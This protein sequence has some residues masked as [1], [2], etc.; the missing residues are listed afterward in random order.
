MSQAL[1]KYLTIT[2]V[3]ASFFQRD[4]EVSDHSFAG[5]IA[6]FAP[7]QVFDMAKYVEA[8]LTRLHVKVDKYSPGMQPVKD[9]NDGVSWARREAI[10]PNHPFPTPQHQLP[11]PPIIMGTYG[12]D[13]KKKTL[14]VYGHYDVQP[15]AKSDGWDTEP[16]VLTER[17]GA[18]YGRG[19]SDDKGAVVVVGGGWDSLTAFEISLNVFLH[20]AR[21]WAGCG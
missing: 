13:P 15:A 18:L 6:A 17:N 21:C 12:E 8:H 4:C 16:F 14:C 9:T 5:F 7:K 1:T 10:N 19:S 3:V 11:L 20:Q 2:L